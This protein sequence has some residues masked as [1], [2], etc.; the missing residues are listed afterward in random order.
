MDPLNGL[1]VKLKRG[2]DIFWTPFGPDTF[3]MDEPPILRGSTLSPA[4]G[5][6]AQSQ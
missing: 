5:V 4:G 6:A 3:M 2:F 1:K